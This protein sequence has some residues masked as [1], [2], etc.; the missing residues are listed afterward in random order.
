MGSSFFLFQI[1]N[2]I[3]VCYALSVILSQLQWKWDSGGIRLEQ[4]ELFSFRFRTDIIHRISIPKWTRSIVLKNMAALRFTTIPRK[5][6]TVNRRIQG[7]SIS[8]IYP[9]KNSIVYARF[10][11]S[12]Y[13]T[14]MVFL[15]LTGKPYGSM[16]APKMVRWS[17]SHVVIMTFDFPGTNLQPLEFHIADW[18][19]RQ[20]THLACWLAADWM[21]ILI[22]N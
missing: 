20:K 15:L 8:E 19:G 7:H 12:C 21:L 13:R 3:K 2:S 16:R 1:K 18:P 14:W 5:S 9:C 10:E 17:H 6:N 22:Q 4:F 11:V